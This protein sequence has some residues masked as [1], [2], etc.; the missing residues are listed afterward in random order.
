MVSSSGIQFY[1]KPPVR[2]T[3]IL[4]FPKNGAKAT[5]TV[6]RIELETRITIKKECIMNM[7]EAYNV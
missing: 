7:K 2:A 5:T 4:P 1:K 3:H 6:S